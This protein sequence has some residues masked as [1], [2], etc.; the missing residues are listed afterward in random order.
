MTTYLMFA[1]ENCGATQ[2]YGISAITPDASYILCT[3]M[4]IDDAQWLMSK[5]KGIRYYK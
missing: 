3:G 5:L 4:Y 1:Q 2:L